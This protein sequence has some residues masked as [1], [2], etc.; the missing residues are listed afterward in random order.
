MS[1]QRARHLAIELGA[2]FVIAAT[3]AADSLRSIWLNLFDEG[4]PSEQSEC[5]AG[6]MRR[7][8]RRSDTIE[9]NYH[10]GSN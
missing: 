1:M 8:S 9:L 2:A 6:L 5:D 4:Q 3:A 7:E 10:V